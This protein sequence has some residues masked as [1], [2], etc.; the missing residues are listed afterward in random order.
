M[1]E[2][3][4]RGV[5]QKPDQRPATKRPG[6]AVDSGAGAVV[7][8]QIEEGLCKEEKKKSTINPIN[9]RPLSPVRLRRVSARKRRRRVQ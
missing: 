9:I 6:K 3:T 4:K 7:A 2:R 8:G 5:G 1:A